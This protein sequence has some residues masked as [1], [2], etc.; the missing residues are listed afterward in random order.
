VSAEA[1][2]KAEL[3]TL[4]GGAE[5]GKRPLFRTE[6]SMKRVAASASRGLKTARFTKGD[7][8]G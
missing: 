2:S 3:K 4:E 5:R 6:N 7:F 8:N 1:W